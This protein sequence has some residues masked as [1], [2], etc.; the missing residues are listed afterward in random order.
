MKSTCLQLI[1]RYS[2]YIK[3][4]TRISIEIRSLLI[5]V[6]GFPIN[7]LVAIMETQIRVFIRSK[8]N[9]SANSAIRSVVFDILTYTNCGLK[10]P[11]SLYFER[12][13]CGHGFRF[14]YTGCPCKC[15]LFDR[16]WD[17]YRIFDVGDC[18]LL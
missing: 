7:R 17:F 16:Q 15:K 1:F 4:C 5:T 12:I 8:G 14:K 2:N 18:L 3:I 6:H 10:V 9:R 13:K 11:Q